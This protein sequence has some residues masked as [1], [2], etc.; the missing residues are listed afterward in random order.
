METRQAASDTL[1]FVVSKQ[2]VWFDEQDAAASALLQTMYTT[3]L[4]F[5]ND[6]HSSAKTTAY[7]RTK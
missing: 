3:H 6:K 2:R 5:I 1:G 4:A 7:C